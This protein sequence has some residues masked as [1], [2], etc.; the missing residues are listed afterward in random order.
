MMVAFNRLTTTD[1]EKTKLEKPGP[2]TK[3]QNL[4]SKFQQVQTPDK[5]AESPVMTPEKKQDTPST[6]PGP[7]PSSSASPGAT[8]KSEVEE[9]QQEGE[10]QATEEKA[11]SEAPGK[12]GSKDPSQEKVEDMKKERWRHMPGTCGVT[13]RCM[14]RVSAV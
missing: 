8:A 10:K 12:E 14:E 13:D 3:P 7:S 6:S 9:K 4:D 1:Q 5:Q 11:T 2:I